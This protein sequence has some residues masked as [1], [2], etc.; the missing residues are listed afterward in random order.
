M[1]LLIKAGSVYNLVLIVFHLMFWRIFG[2][3]TDLRTLSFLNRAIMPVLNLSLTF[4][5]A[6]FAYVSFM[7]SSE[8]LE[9]PLGKSLL[10]LMA[11][12][13][14]FRALLQPVFFKLN[15]WGSVTFMLFF[16][17]GGL[18]YGIPAFSVL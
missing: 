8:L 18:L 14:F 9:T 10:I 4:V 11:I 6:I 15:H 17:C 3:E 5:F 7:H 16:I 2:W 12:F 13:W 1:E